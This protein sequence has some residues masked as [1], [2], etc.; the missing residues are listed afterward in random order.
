M[1]ESITRTRIGI[2]TGKVTTSEFSFKID[3]VEK[4]IKGQ[5][6]IA[7]DKQN[8]K[9]VVLAQIVDIIR[10]G[11]IAIAYCNILGEIRD[12]KLT[13]CKRPIASGSIVYI[14][15]SD[16]LSKM[17]SRTPPDKGLLLG[18]IL[19]HPEFVPIYYNI[20]DLAR[21]FLITAT[22]GGGKSYTIAVIIEEL[23]RIME[24][25]KEN[26]VIVVFDLHNEYGCLVFPNDNKDQIDKLS[27]FN[28]T[29]RGF[30]DRLLVFDWDYNPPHLSPFF[31]PDRLLFIYGV[32]EQKYALILKEL[33]GERSQIKLEDLLNEVEAS[34]L[35]PSTKQA[36]I[37][38]IRALMESGLF[39]DEYITPQK[40]L[41]P[42]FITI[43]RLA[44]TPLGDFGIRFFVADVLKNIFEETKKRRYNFKIIIILDEA[45]FFAPRKGRIDPVREVI[46]RIA[47]EGRK[48]GVWLVLATQSPRDLSKEV[49]MNCNSLLA[50]KLQREDAIELSR[51][52]GID[53]KLVDVFTTLAPGN[54][55]LKAP[56]LT[57]PVFISIRP[58]MSSDL[59][60][61]PHLSKFIEERIK[62]IANKTRS[63]LRQPAK[64]EPPQLPPVPSV[65]EE[66]S[67][68]KPSIK[69][70]KKE[71]KKIVK[72]PEHKLPE[73]ISME[74]EEG[75]IERKKTHK[76]PETKA[77]ISYEK[78]ILYSIIEELRELGIAS[79]QLL[80]EL[81][82][83][84]A[85]PLSLLLA[86]Y[87]SGV[88]DSLKILG[89]AQERGSQLVLTLESFLEN[90]FGRKL[91]R[92]EI[93]RYVDFI[94]DH[95]F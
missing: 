10:T 1:S 49:I 86:K 9:K 44:N 70:P 92:T 89:L 52:F 46:S 11:Q 21:H 6:V 7:I 23:L 58:K 22:T 64:V 81:L 40:V 51:I 55:Y 75:V 78:D 14:P 74:K 66:I 3:D 80:S 95:L 88:I 4:T 76:I 87:D 41:K 15:P 5:Y 94:I 54:G 2:V 36:L 25:K 91:S 17:I 85:I 24:K 62:E 68:P 31:T 42:G 43:F 8:K 57:F 53:S 13:S 71:K 26:T 59:K 20:D 67:P 63:I 12:S 29:P 30:E 39:S 77:R 84:K 65:K 61:S 79:L 69:P 35:H 33:M 38:R 34:D 73:R 56:S 27:E 60:S 32:K 16:L 19:T 90:R 72:P 83:L 45:H 28:L 48:Y 82:R 50:L 18:K 47:R 37:T 93:E